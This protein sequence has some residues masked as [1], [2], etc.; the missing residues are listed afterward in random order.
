MF[1]FLTQI[2]SSQQKTIIGNTT[3]FKNNTKVKLFDQELMKLFDSSYIQNNNF[4]FKNPITDSSPRILSIAIIDSIPKFIR[5]FISNENIKIYGDIKDFPYDIKII[6]SKTQTEQNNFNLKIKSLQ[7]ERDEI[8]KFWKSDVKD[9]NENYQSKLNES[10]I[11][12]KR[13]DRLIDSIKIKQINSKINSYVSLKEL[14]YLK[15]QYSKNELEKIYSNLESKY[16]NSNDGIS[17]L[18]YI[19]IGEVIKE[20]DFYSDFEA[21]DYNGIKHKLSEFNGKSILLDFT[22]EFCEPCEKA[23]KELK[24]IHENYSGKI[25]I[26]SFTG[27]KSKEFWKKGL[28]RNNI[29]WLSLW[30][31]TGANGKTLMKYGVQ[32]FPNFFL[33][34]NKGKIIEI[35]EGYSDGILKPKIEKLLNE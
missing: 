5:L 24:T 31:G 26:I 17:L 35:I 34:N 9:K 7:I 21:F 22:K 6:G 19:N 20:N 28:I 3:G 30:D 32:G 33:I 23:I 12:A 25:T 4:V 29:K 16:K 15:T 10:K 13:I 1:L 11:R 18:N 27:E 2:C 8:V 14:S